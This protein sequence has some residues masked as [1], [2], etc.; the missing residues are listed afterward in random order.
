MSACFN[1]DF[2]EVYLKRGA[3]YP[4]YFMDTEQE[5]N[6]LRKQL[7]EVLAGNRRLPVG[8]FEQKFP[9]PVDVHPKELPTS[10][11]KKLVGEIET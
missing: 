11:P 9:E 6:T 2:D 3:Y 7:L 5:Q 4:K 1:Y 10:Q 8:I